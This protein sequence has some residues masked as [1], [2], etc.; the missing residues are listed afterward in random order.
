MATINELS[1]VISLS[2]TLF[3]FCIFFGYLLLKPSA[4]RT[5]LLTTPT[6]PL[7]NLKRNKIKE[8]CEDPEV[9]SDNPKKDVVNPIYWWLVQPQEDTGLKE[10]RFSLAR[11]SKKTFPY[12]QKKIR[13][14]SSLYTDSSDNL[15]RN[16]S[17]S[18]STIISS[19]SMDLSRTGSSVS[20][21]T[22]VISDENLPNYGACS[23]SN[24][25]RTDSEQSGDSNRNK[26]T[27]F[28]YGFLKTS[29]SN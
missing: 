6:S 3:V 2:V 18:M 1:P 22:S 12:D 28:L 25:L 9:I 29:G 26:R 5:I 27:S 17:I 8:T 11:S 7:F 19:L 10:G 13:R 21:S 14:S 4:K 20:T 15:S 24:R 23:N 16:S